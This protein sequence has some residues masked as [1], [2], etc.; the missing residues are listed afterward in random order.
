MGVPTYLV[1]SLIPIPPLWMNLYWTWI[2]LC[3]FSELMYWSC[4]SLS[5][6]IH[7]AGSIDGVCQQSE[8]FQL[9][10]VPGGR[11]GAG[12]QVLYQDYLLSQTEMH[13]THTELIM[14]VQC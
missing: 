5:S 8:V 4:L 13:C 3:E 2:E 11:S 12:T 6:S 1:F 10:S 14:S 9:W 7:P